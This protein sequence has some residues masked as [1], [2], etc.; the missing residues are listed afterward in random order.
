M[1]ISETEKNERLNGEYNLLNRLANRAS[2]SGDAL[3][4]SPEPLG[5]K[6]EVP[7]IPP[8][9]K[10]IVATA[11][12]SGEATNKEMADAFGISTRTVSDAKDGRVGKRRDEEL[13]TRIEQNVDKIR[14]SAV[15]RIMKS[16][17]VMSD[18]KLENC[19]ARD[20]SGI[21]ANLSK[22]VDNLAPREKESAF[23]GVQIVFYSPRMK[24]VADFEVIDV[25]RTT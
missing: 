12:R 20:L 4:I 8:I 25:E 24:S 1:I 3:I 14:D 23:Q 15:Q 16:L 19:K 2:R 13:E 22:V 11:T 9:I 5:R 21:A 18:E 10:E 7:N 17:N 6:P